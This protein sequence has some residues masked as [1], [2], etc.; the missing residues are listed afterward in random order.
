MR[1]RTWPVFL[2][3]LGSLLALLFLPGITA[4]Q[5]T[6]VVYGEIRDI[7]EAFQA[8][9]ER[10]AEI[11]RR[12]YLTSILVRDLLLDSSDDTGRYRRDFMDARAGIAVQVD[13]LKQQAGAGNHRATVTLENE[14]S[15]YW[16]SIEPVFT[17]T[18]AERSER[19]TY[20]LREQQRPRRTTILAVADELG[21][22]SKAAYKE[23]YERVRQSQEDFRTD[24]ERIV[25]V[26]F[27]LGAAIAGGTTYRISSLER[28]ADRQR[29]KTERA[30]EELRNLSLQ[31]MHA[32]EEERKSISRELH[33]QVGQMLTGLRM[34]L[35][36]LERLREQPEQFHEHLAESKTIAEQSLRA[37]RDL[38]VGLRPSVLDLGLLPALQWHTR[39]YSRQSG[40]RVNLRTEGE[41]DALPETHC[42]CIYRVVQESL[43]NAARHASPSAIEVA[44]VSSANG[45]TA[46][47]QDDGKGFVPARA[48]K[49]GLGLVGMQERV[50]D[51][52]GSLQIESDIGTGTK[53]AVHLPLPSGD[54][55]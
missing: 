51:L 19:G 43:T 40:V 46:T 15:L 27:L 3:G 11:E 6:E 22:L 2:V 48:R 33:D 18:P 26:A 54:R 44:V 25:W 42:M 30:E 34:E 21:A 47:V 4:L 37:I 35:G 52:G 28:R 38:A 1:T 32:Q 29:V 7:Q 12:M 14:L 31:L 24:I 49:M 9:G 39:H 41:F 16:A 55:S 20:F 36:S 17:W 5:R 45:I 50:R 53:L 13:R 10:L 8:S 23:Q